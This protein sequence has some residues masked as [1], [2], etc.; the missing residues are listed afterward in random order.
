MNSKILTIFRRLAIIALII[1][2]IARVAAPSWKKIL[3]WQLGDNDDLMR[4]LQV[5]AWLDGQGF[6]DIINHRLNPPNGGDMHWSRLADI[7]LALGNIILHPFVGT[8]MAEKMAVF[9]VPLILG[10]VFAY[11]AGRTAKTLTGS[12]IALFIGAFMAV[13]TPSAMGYFVAGRVDHH[14]LQ[15]IFMLC[16]FWGLM[17]HDKR[18]AILA[19]LS[20]P[21]S[22]TIGF[23]LAPI[24]VLMVAWVALFWGIRGEENRPQTTI[25]TIWLAIGAFIG[26]FI[27]VPPS[28]YF[29]GVNDALSIAQMAP[30]L[31]GCLLLGL[32][33]HFL[34]KKPIWQRFLALFI[35]GIFVVAIAWQFPILRKEPYWQIEPLLRRLWL[36]VIVETFPLTK[37]DMMVKINLGLF[38][39]VVALAT[40]VKLAFVV[41]NRESAKNH[42]DVDNWSLLAI[43]LGLTTLMAIFWQARVAGQAAA[44]AIVA[45]SAI[46][47]SIYKEKAL[48]HALI[49]GLVLNPILPS[50]AAAAYNKIKPRP[51]T[52]YAVGGGASCLNDPAY[53]H[54]AKMPKGKIVSNIDF[55][56]HALISTHHNVLAAPYHRNRGNFIA[57]DIFLTKADEAYNKIKANDV[58]YVAYCLKSAEIGNMEREN[59]KGL[60]ADLIHGRIPKYLKEIPRAKTSDIVA[61]EVL[62]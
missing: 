25:F 58:S 33:S 59:P 35:I 57:Y 24:Q 51:K 16:A 42:R 41:L 52:I 39:S 13:S 7:P 37:T 53:A 26:F 18:G 40:L 3:V 49:A 50:M 55:G 32:A 28:E 23:E 9:I 38:A 27:N 30:L 47:T 2:A 17:A 44:I 15:L 45:A 21:A 46:I 8:Q 62:P 14:G 48:V 56:A 54:L 11:I 4:V 60:M 31:T 19:G 20:I 12:Y 29:I 61:Y 43:V 1:F 36:A 5:R 22:L 6:Y 10:G 34:S